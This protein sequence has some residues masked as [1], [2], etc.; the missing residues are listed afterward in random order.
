MHQSHPFKL[1][2]ILIFLGIFKNLGDMSYDSIFQTLKCI[3][4]FL[5]S[6][7]K[8]DWSFVLRSIM[9]LGL[10]KLEYIKNEKPDGMKYM[11]MFFSTYLFLFELI[12]IYQTFFYEC[13]ILN[14]C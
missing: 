9:T 11:D 2:T 3:L 1:P 4:N 12:W 14:F 6:K 13:D 5:I 8:C 10:I 7:L